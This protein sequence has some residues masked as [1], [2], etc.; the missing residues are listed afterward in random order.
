MEMTAFD[1]RI[2]YLIEVNMPKEAGKK[3]NGNRHKCFASTCLQ[4]QRL[5]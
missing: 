3:A 5:D 1:S 2:K 4:L